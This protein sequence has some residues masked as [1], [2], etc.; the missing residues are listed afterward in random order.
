MLIKAVIF[1]RA[2][3]KLR[4]WIQKPANSSNADWNTRMVRPG[5]FTASCRSQCAWAWKDRLRAMVRTDA[6]QAGPGAQ[7]GRCS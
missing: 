2:F 1:I 7:G 6:G 5:G 4:W 3:S